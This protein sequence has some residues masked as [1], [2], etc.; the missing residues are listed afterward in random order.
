MFFLAFEFR[1]FW[2]RFTKKYLSSLLEGT[3]I[4]FNY[5]VRTLCPFNTYHK[6]NMKIPLIFRRKSEEVRER[7]ILKI[8]RRSYNDLSPDDSAK[9]RSSR[10]IKR[11]KFD[12]ELGSSLLVVSPGPSGNQIN[13]ALVPSG[14][15]TRSRN[16]SL[17]L[18]EP[19]TPTLTT[20]DVVSGMLYSLCCRAKL[21]DN[22]GI[23]YKLYI[24]VIFPCYSIRRISAEKNKFN[25]KEVW[26]AQAIVGL[27]VVC[28]IEY[29]KKLISQAMNDSYCH[30][31]FICK[32][33]I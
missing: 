2:S 9:R 19:S 30:F 22:D 11:R 14:S 5:L 31:H 12:D 8:R 3:L 24:T 13:S 27:C 16:S 7:N 33:N 18:A 4:N 28:T 25:T 20:P 32:N 6:P 21:C 10:A 15:E 17:C 29:I 26:V 23:L 1:F